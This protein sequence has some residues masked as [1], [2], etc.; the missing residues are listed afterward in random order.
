MPVTASLK[1]LQQQE[2]RQ[3]KARRQELSPGVPELSGT[4]AREP[5]PAASRAE[6]Q[7]AAAGAG[8]GAGLTPCSVSRWNLNYCTHTLA[9]ED[10]NIHRQLTSPQ[11]GPL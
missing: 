9:N 5:S 6:R 4:Q 2:L 1:Y 7:A 11:R 8:T 3:S 10:L